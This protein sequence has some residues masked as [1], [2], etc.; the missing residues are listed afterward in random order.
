MVEPFFYLK[1][2]KKMHQ[3]DYL[4]EWNF[5]WVKEKYLLV[6][7]TIILWNEYAAVDFILFENFVK[8]IYIVSISM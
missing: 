5:R 4:N 8:D 3:E 2:C 7:S 1:V 6:K